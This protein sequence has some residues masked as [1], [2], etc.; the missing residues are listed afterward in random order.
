MSKLIKSKSLSNH[1]V[2]KP[3]LSS[4]EES[5]E[6]F[7]T[8]H[9]KE[10]EEVADSTDHE[11]IWEE[12]IRIGYEEG[13]RKGYEVGY[14]EGYEI[15][16]KRGFEEGRKEAERFLE[17]ERKKLQANLEFEKKQTITKIET[18]IK[19]LDEEIR[20]IVLDLDDY[21]LKISLDLAKKL[22]FKEI[23]TDRELLIRI[24]R[25]ALNY[26]AEGTEILIKVNPE[27]I[28]F[29]ES[30]LEFFPQNYKIKILSDMS[31]SKGGLF[32]ETTLGVIDATFEKRWEKILTTLSGKLNKSSE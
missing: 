1:S 17:E 8:S 3:E 21:I 12:K 14:E 19:R 6:L 9:T 28:D 27:D 24:I 10:N 25:E 23:E 32:I 16:M 2:F 30:K 11:K 22:V 5:F 31:I 18:F 15:A 4:E 13:Y 29:L 20:K 26:I 7:I